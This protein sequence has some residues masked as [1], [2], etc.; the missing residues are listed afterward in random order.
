[1]I[2]HPLAVVAALAC[3]EAGVLWVSTRPRLKK[4]FSFLPPVFWIYFLPMLCA[5]FGLLDPASSVYKHIA[6]YVLPASLVLLLL[7]S[8][9]KAIAR[10][11]P[12]SL[13]MMLAGSFGVML[14]TSTVLFF[15][16]RHF[17]PQSWSGFGSLSA[18]WIGGSANMIAVKESLSTPDAVFAPMV[19]V[20]TVVPYTWM[21][22][23]IA[24]AGAQAVF[25]KWNR[26]DNRLLD[27]LASRVKG[28]DCQSGSSGKSPAAF[29][30]IAAVAL[31]GM[32][33][34][35]EIS[36]LIPEIPNVLSRYAWMI[37]CVSCIG[38]ALSFT[39][40]RKLGNKGATDIGYYLLYFVLTSIGAKS[41]IDSPG[42]ALALIGAGFLIVAIHAVVLLIAARF[43]RA[44]LFL[45]AT[46]SQANIGG[47]ASAPVVAAMYQPGLASVGLLLAVFGNIMGTYLG[48]I[49][50]RI[51]YF[52][53]GGP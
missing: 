25:D 35:R 4:Y 16:G 38:I 9:I 21:A 32:F 13:I 51:G 24:F 7:S 34:S 45:V 53:L 27:D 50:G 10:L 36:G 28:R 5:T 15:F 46:A 19:I 43:I 29:M 47:V 33:F 14:G 40:C 17:G 52:I 37:I 22:F 12:A 26:A 42:A 31:L 41:S 39:P 20:D 1:M 3:I 48:I 11:G 18:S 30:L 2:R 8:D 44:P 6:D 23:L 49:T